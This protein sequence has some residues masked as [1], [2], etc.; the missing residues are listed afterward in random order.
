MAD[1]DSKYKTTAGY[2]NAKIGTETKEEI[3]KSMETSGIGE[4]NE[5]GGRLIDFT[6]LQ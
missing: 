2:F 4:I 6:D 1:G 3:F 5:R